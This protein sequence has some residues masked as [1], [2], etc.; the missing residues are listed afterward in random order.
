MLSIENTGARRVCIHTHLNMLFYLQVHAGFTV[1]YN[2]TSGSSSS[3]WPQHSL[4]LLASATGAALLLQEALAID[5]PG[6][7]C[8]NT[9]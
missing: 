7:R 1:T 9:F 2:L 4:H 8:G 6:K 3:Q 5:T